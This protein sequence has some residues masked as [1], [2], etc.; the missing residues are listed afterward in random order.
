[1]PWFNVS[2]ILVL[3]SIIIVSLSG[4]STFS[5]ISGSGKV[6]TK[7]ISY[8]DFT[9]ID[10]GSGFDVE[11]T[12]SNSYSI[13]VTADGDLFDNLKVRHQDNTLKM[14]VDPVYSHISSIKKVKITMPNIS[15]LK[16]S[17]GAKGKI[18]GFSSSDNFNADL[19]LGSHLSGNIDA[20]NVDFVIASGS[21]I[22]LEGS[23]SNMTLDASTGSKAEL[24]NFVLDK[25][26]VKLSSGSNATIKVKAELNV[27]LS[28]GSTLHYLGSP[29]I[30]NISISGGSTIKPK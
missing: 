17:T 13:I 1:M 27:D 7:E 12:Q 9:S 30:D 14:H 23:A 25:A 2:K 11:V 20:S 4:C 28:L 3:S 15:S 21:S 18:K 16:L 29:K 19:S 6:V 10:I 5:P 8:S 22:T 24:S 26:T